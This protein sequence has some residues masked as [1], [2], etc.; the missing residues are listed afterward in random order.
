MAS[1]VGTVLTLD[2]TSKNAK[3]FLGIPEKNKSVTIGAEKPLRRTKAKTLLQDEHYYYESTI[4]NEHI[5]IGDEVDVFGDKVIVTEAT[6]K[7]EKNDGVLRNLYRLEHLPKMKWYG[8]ERVKGISL[9]GEILDVKLDH[10]KIHLDIDPN[11]SVSEAF[12]YP[13][14]AEAN[15]VWH[16]MP[17]IGERVNLHIADI[18]ETGLCMTETRGTEAQMGTPKSLS[19]PNE[20]YMLT[21]WNKQMALHEEDIEWDIL[22]INILMTEES[23]YVDSNDTIIIE[24]D[25]EMNIGKTEFVYFENGQKRVR[26]EETENITFEAEELLTFQVTSTES[27]IELDEYNRIHSP[28]DVQK[29]GGHSV[30]KPIVGE[31]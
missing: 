4:P 19:N 22:K 11:Q 16:V 25:A 24:T 8:N 15:N 2:I 9:E 10:V 28:S 14:K 18:H 23:V 29:F 20:K 3:L 21:K 17:H 5:K 12:W 27:I 26:I 7:Y 30:P 1:E 13:C 31:R 6:F